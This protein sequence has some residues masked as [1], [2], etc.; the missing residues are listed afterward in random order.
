MEDNEELARNFYLN[1]TEE[2]VTRERKSKKNRRKSN[3][4]EKKKDNNR[5]KVDSEKIIA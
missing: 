5:E 1:D 3:S 4:V 2:N